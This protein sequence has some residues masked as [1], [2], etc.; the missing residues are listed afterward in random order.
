M[1]RGPA[2]AA[3]AALARPVQHH[4]LRPRRPLPRRQ[5]RASGGVRQ[6]RGHPRARLRR[7]RRHRPRERVARRQRAGGAVLPH[8]VLRP[9]ARLR[10]RLLPGD[11]PARAA[12]LDRGEE[13]HP[14]LQV[15][16]GAP[17]PSR[18]PTAGTA[19]GRPTRGPG[20][21]APTSRTTWP[22]DDMTNPERD[23]DELALAA[24]DTACGVEVLAPREV[25][26]GGP[27][28]MT[29]RRTL[30]QRGPVA[31]RRVVLRR[32]LRPR[33]GRRHRRHVGRPAPAHRAADG[34]LALHRRDR[35]PRL[36][37]PPR[38][39]PPRRGQPDDR[40][41][42]HQPLGG[43]HARHHRA[44]RRPAVGGPAR[45]RRATSSRP[46]ST[47]RPTRSPATGGRPGC[48]SARCS[49]SRRRCRPTRRSSAP[50]CCSPRAP[51]WSSRSTRPSSTA[52]SST[53]GVATVDGQEGKPG[54]LVY[55]APGPRH[56]HRRGP[57]GR[58]GAAARRPAVR[59]V[60]RHVVE[61]RGPHP[62]GGRRLPR[63]V[64]GAGRRRR[65]TART[66]GPAG[67]ASWSATT[68]PRSR[69]RPAE[70]AAAR[71][72]LTASPCVRRRA[73]A[74]RCRRSAS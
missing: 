57:R 69:R 51:R 48:S 58:A 56:A 31:D 74:R 36:G 8:R 28:A 19:T 41:P 18:A 26:L 10:R 20:P 29:V 52:C 34:E 21:S 13:Q 53:A 9:A 72:A 44:A 61:L 54:E 63:G 17:R 35:A 38:D 2:A 7:R 65:P 60:H 73:A 5:G 46:S 55:A 70:R 67:T 16:G 25:P 22:E 39:G 62:R 33:P 30:P 12:R 66:S 11:Q 47:T 6:P 59:R 50:S 45:G 24:G 15:G 49:G 43:L 68:C 4:D 1:P 42:G 3:D 32:P 71:A 40:R 27:R 64:A 14:G 23:P 37:R